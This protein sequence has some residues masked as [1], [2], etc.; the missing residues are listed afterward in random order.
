MRSPSRSGASSGPWAGTSA[1]S[2]TTP[3]W[4]PPRSSPRTCSTWTSRSPG[5][6]CSLSLAQSCEKVLLRLSFCFPRRGVLSAF[7]QRQKARKREHEHLPFSVLRPGRGLE[8]TIGERASV[9]FSSPAKVIGHINYGGR[10]TDDKDR[11]LRATY[12]TL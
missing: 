6:R 7:T 3:T 9:Q 10:V 12:T 1:T 2:S 8:E 5:T 11:I 4:R